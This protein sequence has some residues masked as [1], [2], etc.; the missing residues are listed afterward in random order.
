[1]SRTREQIDTARREGILAG[2][3]PVPTQECNFC[4]YRIPPRALWCGYSCAQE[5]EA[6]RREL[7]GA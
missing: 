3:K 1:M 5:Y 2:R 4:G 7:T 6:E